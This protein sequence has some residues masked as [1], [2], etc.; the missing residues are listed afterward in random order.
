[1]PVEE[2]S[3]NEQIFV[4]Y[5]HELRKSLE[6]AI[7]DEL[8]VP[9][10]SLSL[11]PEQEI[12]IFLVFKPS[13]DVRS[14]NS[15][16]LKKIEE[17]LSIQLL[18]TSSLQEDLPDKEE[19]PP[20]EIIIQAKICPSLLGI[21]Q[22]HINF[23]TMLITE[24]KEKNI[25]ITNMSEVPLFY[26][27][28]KTGSVASSD[29][30]IDSSMIAIVRPY[31]NRELHLLFKPSFAGKF[32][33]T[34]RIENIQ[35]PADSKVITIKA[36][37]MQLERFT[38]KSSELA[39]FGTIMCNQWSERRRIILT[40]MTKHRRI[41]GVRN[42]VTRM[43][44]C[45]IEFE[46]DLQLCSETAETDKLEA[47]LEKTEHKLRI[48]IRKQKNDKVKKLSKKVVEIKKL[49]SFGN[50]ED[51]Q[52]GTS[53]ED[54]EEREKR[55]EKTELGIQFAIPGKTTQIIHV[56]IRAIV[57][58][59]V[60]AIEI[61]TGSGSFVISE[62]KNQDFE[63][64]ISFDFVVQ[65]ASPNSEQWQQLLQ[66]ASIE[67]TSIIM[68]NDSIV[69]ASKEHAQETKN[70]LPPS[71][72]LPSDVH[73]NVF[74][75][76]ID[77][78]RVSV[79]EPITAQITIQ[80]ISA[81]YTC[82]FVILSPTEK[83]NEA[84]PVKFKFSKRNAVLSKKEKVTI[85]ITC[86]LQTIGPQRY[87]ISVQN[88]V[89]KQ[90]HTVLIACNPTAPPPVSF[91]G[92]S[93]STNQLLAL[94]YCYVDNKKKYALVHQFTVL[95]KKN[96]FLTLDI[97]SNTP[98]QIKI[99]QDVSLSQ[100]AHNVKL[101]PHAEFHCFICLTPYL[102]PQAIEIGQ[103]RIL[104]AG[105]KIK[106]SD[107]KHVVVLYE[108]SIPVKAYVG[109]SILHCS[110]KMIDFGCTTQLGKTFSGMFTLSNKNQHLPLE[111]AM[112]IPSQIKL[113]PLKGRLEPMGN[114]KRSSKT[115][116]FTMTAKQYGLNNAVIIIKNLMCTEKE[117]Q[118]NVRIF[119][120]DKVLQTGLKKNQAG[121][122]CLKFEHLYVTLP[123]SEPTKSVVYISQTEQELI[124]SLQE[125][126]VTSD[127]MVSTVE[128]LSTVNAVTLKN[129][130]NSPMTLVPQADMNLEVITPASL[131]V[132]DMEQRKN[133]T[134]TLSNSCGI[135]FIL[136]PQ[137]ETH[138]YVILKSL[139]DNN[140]QHVESFKLRKMVTFY[141]TLMINHV[142]IAV[143]RVVKIIDVTAQ[144]CVS[145]GTLL[146][147][148]VNV[149]KFGYTTS[150]RNKNFEFKL[151]NLS[152]MPLSLVTNL[153]H[154]DIELLGYQKGE[155]IRIDPLVTSTFK[156][157]LRTNMFERLKPGTIYRYIGFK[158]MY[159]SQ[160]DMNLTVTGELTTRI[161]RTNNLQ[162][163]QSILL[164]MLEVPPRPDYAPCD[165]SFCIGN[166]SNNPITVKFEVNT[167]YTFK[168][169]LKL[170]L[171]NFAT[172]IPLKE[173]KFAPQM[174]LDMRIRCTALADASIS[175][176]LLEHI[177]K[178]Q[179][180]EDQKHQPQA[181]QIDSSGSTP[182]IR[183]GEL[184]MIGLD[185]PIEVFPIYGSLAQVPTFSLSI[186]RL[187]F[188][189]S[190]QS[191]V[192]SRLFS[193]TFAIKNIKQKEAL[194]FIIEPRVPA[195][196][197]FS[198][199]VVPV[200]G[201][202]EAGG[203]IL[204]NTFLDLADFPLDE[205]FPTENVFLII[206]DTH[207]PLASETV[208]VK[209][210]YSPIEEPETPGTTAF[211]QPHFSHQHQSTLPSSSTL[212]KPR[213]VIKG[214]T[215]I[216]QDQNRFEINIGQQSFKSSKPVKWDLSL[217]NPNTS[218]PVSY[219]I[220]TISQESGG[221]LKLSQNEG[222]L[223]ND[224]HIITL[225]F[226]TSELGVFS[227]YLLVE[228]LHN[229]KDMSI[230]RV[231]MEVVLSGK[232]SGE[233]FFTVLVDDLPIAQNPVLDMGEVFMG[234][235]VRHRY[236]DICNL[237]QDK[238]LEFQIQLNHL[239]DGSSLPLLSQ[240]V[241][242]PSSTSNNGGISQ[243]LLHQQQQQHSP[244]QQ[245]LVGMDSITVI[246]EMYLS[247]SFTSFKGFHSLT[248]EPQ[249]SA[250]V[251]VLYKPLQLS[252]QSPASGDNSLVQH[253]KDDAE[254]YVRCR[255]VKDY[256]QVVKVRAQCLLPQMSISS[257]E[258][259]FI[260]EV[261]DKDKY[262]PKSAELTIKNLMEEPLK[263]EVRS[264][265]CLCF[266]VITPKKCIISGKNT[267]TLTVLPVMS[268]IQ[269]TSD[270]LHNKSVEE[271]F[272]IYNRKNLRE[273]WW[274]MV[275]FTLSSLSLQI[276]PT[277]GTKSG[278]I[279]SSLEERILLFLSEF[280]SQVDRN[281]SFFMRNKEEEQQP[282]RPEDMEGE[283][284]AIFQKR[285]FLRLY[286]DLHYLTDELVFYALKGKVGQT[287][288]DLAKLLY[289]ALLNHRIFGLI[290]SNGDKPIPQI[291]QLI[292]QWG[293]Q[294]THFLS[295]FP[296]RREVKM[297]AEL[298]E[299]VVV[300]KK[301]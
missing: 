173:H 194:H 163:D 19:I 93:N 191:S 211:M 285:S 196:S 133:L 262:Q 18:D 175:R 141:G 17:K 251:F 50:D 14:F 277:P 97:T 187:I 109:Y 178:Q 201:V 129:T 168:A 41:F 253:Y 219:A 9:L 190:H 214:C 124:K 243:Q 259:N 22:R 76:E 273:K 289:C 82:G 258:L 80:N 221:W 193:E 249:T 23:G 102:S 208:G 120:D 236:I 45:S 7:S 242:T 268:Q 293:G 215:L 206:S 228:N 86:E 123:P 143:P 139:P 210:N 103:C 297:L 131:Q 161:W 57:N 140:S 238:A 66:A 296:H 28:I 16:T 183:F 104:S 275:R 118:I 151:R 203:S 125:F 62:N 167:D 25:Y 32:E 70:Q 31:G 40:N 177:S 244:V 185:Q 241:S 128:D 144:V 172:N 112:E 192:N 8:L 252:H 110:A 234:S 255:L 217:E 200:R 269:K 271:H 46:Y 105:I 218:T 291:P 245:Q 180:Q 197:R 239:P 44:G 222:T 294:L 135:P 248:I 181:Q 79:G 132:L 240:S 10:T 108:R 49:L 216:S 48:A 12:E 188:Y 30:K 52:I 171:L 34:I 67:D 20:R 274:I 106:V 284:L 207:A 176:K 295:Y 246:K 42:E 94:G 261:A 256:Q 198:L 162:E 145:E 136:A 235:M 95:N 21:T 174:P 117:L 287:F 59:T 229:A 156:G 279:F 122:D 69:P 88:L 54:T 257:S 87:T 24:E 127:Q 111:F 39:N 301:M 63:K 250:R 74:P 189:T 60:S 61:E 56:A 232:E 84:S 205:S 72:T 153:E 292:K 290:S 65:Y 15:S 27:I 199:T 152:E 231:H 227:T 224:T 288:F 166:T 164:P 204:V 283:L 75:T 247:L 142:D 225:N 96:E 3:D 146:A 90:I 130:G 286:F 154:D 116:K 91:P 202:I 71:S 121:I 148:S 272:T 119:V 11:L 213:L 169:I 233:K 114:E 6:K 51:S 147:S 38:L 89:T 160:N 226:S 278:V 13:S 186:G 170:D 37:I 265:F 33:E 101:M 29:L 220:K 195:Q 212:K 2:G 150:W 47:E 134:D 36:D 276:F 55:F 26:R 4:R 64:R 280:S 184:R 81:S 299:K 113:S 267:H 260:G 149:G 281:V 99:F 266:S 159:N 85:Y 237:T 182:T 223:L 73:L 68:A 165:K 126:G 35:D 83:P 43:K 230:I 100:P 53:G 158:N 263:Y 92:L 137:Q 179:K 77:L 270:W 5:V 254:L 209:L 115:I 107:E 298:H 282:Q 300:S 138:L 264:D 78:G 157:L 1:M 155:I 58:P 98:N